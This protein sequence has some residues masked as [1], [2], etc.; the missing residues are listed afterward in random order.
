MEKMENF[1]MYEVLYY[2]G[3][4]AEQCN[5]IMGRSKVDALKNLK[6]LP[7]VKRAGNLT[8]SVNDFEELDLLSK[9]EMFLREHTL[10][11]YQLEQTNFQVDVRI[12]RV[13]E[14][15]WINNKY[16]K[17]NMDLTLE[18]YQNICEYVRDTIH[19]LATTTNLKTTN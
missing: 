4:G 9:G 16:S 17:V 5:W 1:K 6:N 14:H 18:Y 15:S 7:I 19:T 10:P 13:D 11:R 8:A 2:V 12:S 3:D